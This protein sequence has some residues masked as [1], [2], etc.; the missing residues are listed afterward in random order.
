LSEVEPLAREF[1]RWLQ[2]KLRLE[3]LVNLEDVLLDSTSIEVV[4]YARV[5]ESCVERFPDCNIGWKT[6][7]KRWYFGKKL[8]LVCDP[9]GIIIGYRLT[10]ASIHDSRVYSKLNRKKFKVVTA[11]SGY[12][13]ERG[14]SGQRLALTQPFAT[15]EKQRQLAG[16]RVCI[17][18]VNNVLKKLGLESR[19]ILKSARSLGSHIQAVLTCVL[20]IQYLNVKNGRSPLAY[21]AFLL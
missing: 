18:R 7:E 19:L 17:E 9:T 16:K 3:E 15:S 6:T 2:L 8:H 13:G 12:R 14:F 10:R 4:L 1:W 20:G 11:D 5:E 21:G